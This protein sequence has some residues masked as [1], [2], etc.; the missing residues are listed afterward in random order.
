MTP[1]LWTHR[2]EN[3]HDGHNSGCSALWLWSCVD[4]GTNVSGAIV[5]MIGKEGDL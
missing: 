1:F 3:T 2:L 4:K 5:N